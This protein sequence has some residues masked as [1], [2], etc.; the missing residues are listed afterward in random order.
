[1]NQKDQMD[2]VTPFEWG[3]CQDLVMFLIVIR[4]FIAPGVHTVLL[5]P[6]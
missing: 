4:F 6:G 5:T 1:V 3:K 2:G